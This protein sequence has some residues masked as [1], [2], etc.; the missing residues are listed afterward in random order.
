MDKIFPIEIFLEIFQ[1]ISVVDLYYSWYNL[2]SRINLIL[3][4]VKL[5]IDLS[6]DISQNV[7]KRLYE[8]SISEL[9]HQIYYI[10]Q[11]CP[12]IP[13]INQF[14]NVRTLIIHYPSS[15]QLKQIKPTI[16]KYLTCLCIQ[17]SPCSSKE[18]EHLCRLLFSGQFYFLKKCHLSYINEI[19]TIITSTSNIQSLTI[20]K[21]NKNDLYLIIKYLEKLKYLSVGIIKDETLATV[22]LKHLPSIISRKLTTLKLVIHK[23]QMHFYEFEYIASYL[24]NLNYLFVKAFDNEHLNFN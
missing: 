6:S 2:N 14:I 22:T 15:D 20:A 19:K 8:Q 18:Y 24:P 13:N 9:H 23:Y 12:L 7:Y 1:Y 3:A 11:Y 17:Y 21:C 10:R 4:D 16:F 5:S